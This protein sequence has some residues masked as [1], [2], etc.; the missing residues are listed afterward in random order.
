MV[1]ENKKSE[2]I[3]QVNKLFHD[4]VEKLKDDFYKKHDIEISNQEATKIIAK[5]IVSFGGIKNI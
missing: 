3:I 2:P 5:K 1:E 4:I